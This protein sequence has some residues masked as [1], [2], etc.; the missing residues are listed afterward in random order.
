[1]AKLLILS[2]VVAVVQGAPSAEPQQPLVYQYNPWL[3]A[4]PLAYNVFP[5]VEV[6]PSTTQLIK[7]PYGISESLIFTPRPAF[8]VGEPRQVPSYRQEY[9]VL[10]NIYRDMQAVNPGLKRSFLLEE[11]AQSLNTPCRISSHY[12]HKK[13]DNV[14]RRWRQSTGV[15]SGQGAII[16]APGSG[17][18]DGECY[19]GVNDKPH[20]EVCWN[21]NDPLAIWRADKS[22]GHW[23]QIEDRKNKWVG[24]TAHK[25]GDEAIYIWCYLTPYLGSQWI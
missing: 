14:L 4:P 24:C 19:Y 21:R 13:M 6:K 10:R 8:L 20:I 16:S 12:D 15:A 3:Y 23:S 9:D 18:K 7:S 22:S 2:F 11:L 5:P 1:M 25:C 17:H